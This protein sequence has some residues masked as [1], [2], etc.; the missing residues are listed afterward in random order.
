MF[1]LYLAQP[2]W[3][4]RLA[5]GWKLTALALISL[6]V[7]PV[8]SLWLLVAALL[9]AFCGHLSLGAPGIRRLVGLL[10]TLLPMLLFLATAQWFTFIFTLGFEEGLK[11]GLEQALV[12]LV[13]I[14]I[15]VM[16]ADLVTLSS[17]S[18]EL[19]SALRVFL[20]PLRSIGLSPEKLSLAM[21]LV[22][23]WVSL[24]QAEWSHIRA[25]F[26]SRGCTKPRL[27][28]AIPLVRRAQVMSQTM[29]DALEARQPRSRS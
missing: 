5:A 24:L 21:A 22:F 10:K 15:M 27:R 23:R 25:S 7:L 11:P 14:L 17:T 12:T 6:M 8:T 28:S 18:Q 4:H 26:L 3:L 9:V 16:L 13:R 29:A 20:I 19:I 1:S 2:T